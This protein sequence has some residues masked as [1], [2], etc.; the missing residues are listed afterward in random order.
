MLVNIKGIDHLLIR[1]AAFVLYWKKVGGNVEKTVLPVFIKCRNFCSV[2]SSN[3]SVRKCGNAKSEIAGDATCMGVHF[4]TFR[5]VLVHSP[6]G[7]VSPRKVDYGLSKPQESNTHG[8]EEW[9]LERHRCENLKSRNRTA[10]TNK[11]CS[12]AFR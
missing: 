8:P 4:A 10:A 7:L 1:N 9:D 6:S 5:F 12:S 2:T 11:S 3:G